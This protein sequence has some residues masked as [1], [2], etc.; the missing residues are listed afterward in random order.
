[1]LYDCQLNDLGKLVCL[2]P[3]LGAAA[4]QPDLDT[5]NLLML[6]QVPATTAL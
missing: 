5:L 4:V 1:M 3:S 6:S 2:C